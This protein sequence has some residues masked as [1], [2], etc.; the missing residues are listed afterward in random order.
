[1]RMTRFHDTVDCTRD[2]IELSR[3]NEES[4][5]SVEDQGFQRAWQ[6]VLLVRR[7]EGTRREEPSMVLLVKFRVG[8]Y[9]TLVIGPLNLFTALHHSK[10][11]HQSRS[12]LEWFSIPSLNS[13]ST[14]FVQQRTLVTTPSKHTLVRTASKM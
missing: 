6:D 12:I 14:F 9:G 1:M 13:I 8:V 2:G 3:R 11:G 7:I 4:A 10:R 5:L